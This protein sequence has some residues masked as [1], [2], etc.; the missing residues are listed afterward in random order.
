[1]R[2][3]NG[4]DTLNVSFKFN[5]HCQTVLIQ[6]KNEVMHEVESITNDDQWELISKFGLLEEIFNFF[7][8]VKVA[9]FI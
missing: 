5:D 2:C 8:I 4:V 3:A 7:G 6:I 1:M 9:L